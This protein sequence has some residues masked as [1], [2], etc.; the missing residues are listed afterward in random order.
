MAAAREHIAK[1][2]HEAE[3]A[4]HDRQAAHHDIYEKSEMKT[5]AIHRTMHKA[6]A[7]GE[8]ADS[9][10]AQ[11]AAEAES[12][13]RT[14]RADSA[15]H[16]SHAAHHLA[17]AAKCSKAMDADLTKIVPDRVSGLVPTAPAFGSRAIPRTGQ[18]PLDEKPNVPLEF[19][20]LVEI[21]DT[22]D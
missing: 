18:R 21:E 17:A 22:L 8:D 12:R 10:H 11:L 5:A 16:R 9:P 13:A 15:D 20:R 14:H 19:A 1:E 6:S 3:A 4:H 7:L 2:I